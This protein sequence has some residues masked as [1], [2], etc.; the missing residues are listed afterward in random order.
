N[1][2]QA[3][4]PINIQDPKRPHHSRSSSSIH[5]NFETN[6]M[7]KVMPASIASTTV[8]TA[9]TAYKWTGCTANSPK[10]ELTAWLFLTSNAKSAKFATKVHVSSPANSMKINS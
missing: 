2:D 8:G 5:L 1:S 7:N 10:T 3:I 9:N 4:M 6:P